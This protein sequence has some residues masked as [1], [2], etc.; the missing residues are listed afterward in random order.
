MLLLVFSDFII[1]ENDGAQETVIEIP[2]H[3]NTETNVRLRNSNEYVMFLLFNGIGGDKVNLS[4]LD[5]LEVNRRLCLGL[6]KREN[7]QTKLIYIITL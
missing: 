1:Q 3:N 4:R 6:R 2:F 5:L 7:V